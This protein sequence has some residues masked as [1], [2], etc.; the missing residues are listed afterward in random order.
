MPKPKKYKAVLLIEKNNF[1]DV[2]IRIFKLTLDSS[3]NKKI[4]KIKKIQDLKKITRIKNIEYLFNFQQYIINEEILNLIKYPINFHPGPTTYPG[5][6]GYVWA[7]FEKSKKYGCTAH[8]MKKKVDSGKIIDEVKFPLEKFETIETIKFKSFLTNLRVFYNLLS[9][10]N[11]NKNVR[12]KKIKWK[13]KTLK[14][15]DL[16]KINT[17]NK[18]TPKNLRKLIT[19]A[20]EY[21]P[22]GPF[23]LDGNK[24]KKI[25]IKKKKHII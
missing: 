17:F 5:R 21:Y 12:F 9:N 2:L 8:I 24:V 3:F 20:T 16:K 14:L 11:L 18:N 4:I 7:I 1:S 22:F 25:K 10:L 15:E 23:M 6:G 13:R 19:R